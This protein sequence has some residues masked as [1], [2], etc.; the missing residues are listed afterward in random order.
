MGER[1]RK[2]ELGYKQ[3]KIVLV[4]CYVSVTRLRGDYS[5]AGKHRTQSHKWSEA[6]YIIGK[7]RSIPQLWFIR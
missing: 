3:K 6:I 5:P 7:L 2:R 1:M 4:L